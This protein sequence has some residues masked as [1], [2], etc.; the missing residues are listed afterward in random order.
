M[1][2]SC[3]CLSGSLAFEAKEN[4]RSSINESESTWL[5]G[6]EGGVSGRDG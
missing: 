5:M 2:T 3:S 6:D 4:A 1:C